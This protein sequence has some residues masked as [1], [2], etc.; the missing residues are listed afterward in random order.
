MPIEAK[1][2]AH[3]M[4]GNVHPVAV[5]ADLEKVVDRSALDGLDKNFT[6]I[7]QTLNREPI[8]A[9]TFLF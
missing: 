2:L 6:W 4:L 7:Q 3:L 9:T 5:V 1:I 8:I